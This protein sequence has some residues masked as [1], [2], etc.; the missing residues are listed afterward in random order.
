ME[1]SGKNDNGHSPHLF[2]AWAAWP[3]TSNNKRN[4][5]VDCVARWLK[6]WPKPPYKFVCVHTQNSHPINPKRMTFL[7]KRLIQYVSYPQRC[8]LGDS[9]WEW[10]ETKWMKT[11]WLLITQ[12]TEAREAIRTAAAPLLASWAPSSS[13]P[14]FPDHLKESVPTPM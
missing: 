5:K 3:F 12:K 7:L 13:Q 11:T 10:Q 9:S 14:P 8:G 1:Y 4:Q 6:T 2:T